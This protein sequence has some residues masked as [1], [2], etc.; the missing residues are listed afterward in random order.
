MF[1]AVLPIVKKGTKALGEEL[2][3]SGANAVEDIWRTGDLAT[4][5][6]RRG[7]ELL[8]NIS[9]RVSNHMFGSGYK[10]LLGVRRKPLKRAGKRKK[11]RKT[12]K[13]N[14]KKRKTVKRKKKIVKKKKV[15][16]TKQNIQDIF[17]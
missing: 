11:A 1:R 3:K 12:V 13:R 5:K 6:K 8:T 10:N 7:K 4:T 17:S 2:L 16:R 9:N 15:R 14:P